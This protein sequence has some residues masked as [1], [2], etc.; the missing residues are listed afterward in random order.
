[1]YSSSLA[2]DY[3]HLFVYVLI[4]ISLVLFV[5]SLGTFQFVKHAY[6]LVECVECCRL[7]G[8]VKLRMF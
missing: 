1:M 2:L 6:C 5:D 8:S 3:E 7:S 4:V